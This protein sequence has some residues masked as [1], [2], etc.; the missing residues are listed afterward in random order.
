MN[1]RK[2][3]FW[4]P[5]ALWLAVLGMTS[6]RMNVLPQ[7]SSTL[8]PGVSNSLIAIGTGSAGTGQ[9]TGFELLLPIDEQLANLRK[10]DVA[11]AYAAASKE[12]QEATTLEQFKQFIERYPLFLSHRT[13]SVVL[14]VERGDK[15]EVKV[16]LNPKEEAVTV[17][18]QLIHDKDGKWKIWS[19]NIETPY[20]STTAALLQNPGA[21]RIPV[22]GQIQAIRD[23]NLR[24][25][26]YDYTSKEFQ[27]TTPFDNFGK[28]IES[29]GIILQHEAVDFKTPSLEKG[30]GHI[31][32]DFY[33]KGYIL[34]LEYTL[35]IEEDAWR[36]WGITVLKQSTNVP[37]APPEEQEPLPESTKEP[38]ALGDQADQEQKPLQFV[39][40]EVGTTIN[41][42]GKIIDPSTTLN[43]PKG[44]LHTNLYIRDGKAG[45]RIEVKLLHI[46]SQSHL[47]PISTTLQ[48]DGNSVLSVAFS[49]PAPGWPKGHY[50]LEA[51]SSSGIART[52]NFIVN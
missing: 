3:F 4:I 16:E 12:F 33:N 27:K 39:K 15:A 14:Q 24:K 25:A 37:E 28:F 23:G 44:D 8:G 42:K 51:S 49:P 38:H 17:D 35:G 9:G 34:S 10:G 20:S 29:F 21:L 5:A 45:D 18:Y 19:M 6:Y 40:Y 43:S 48:Q 11:A 46:E 26:Y 41:A 50:Q 31:E 47:P 36:I 30:T 52:F 22:E 2:W 32:V 13:L 1:R 7:F